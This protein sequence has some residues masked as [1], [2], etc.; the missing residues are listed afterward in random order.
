MDVK[1]GKSIILKIE[2]AINSNISEMD[3]KILKEIYDYIKKDLP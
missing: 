2:S 1:E 3:K